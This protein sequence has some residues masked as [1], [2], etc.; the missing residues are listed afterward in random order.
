MQLYD[1][2]VKGTLISQEPSKKWEINLGQSL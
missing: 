1:L 2:H